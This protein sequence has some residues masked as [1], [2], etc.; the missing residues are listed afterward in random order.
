M[1]MNIH[2]A[3]SFINKIVGPMADDKT[4]I[5]GDYAANTDPRFVITPR[6]GLSGLGDDVAFAAGCQSTHC[7]N[8]SSSSIKV[9]VT[10]ADLVIVCLG[11][12]ML[13]TYKSQFN[14]NM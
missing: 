12:G 2:V 8:Y 10:S 9:A 5:M 7:T 1:N 11:T 13:L 14:C 3:L 4:Q 6:K